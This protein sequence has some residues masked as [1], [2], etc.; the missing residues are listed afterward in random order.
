MPYCSGGMF[1]NKFSKLHMHRSETQS[2]PPNTKNA[3]HSTFFGLWC[4]HLSAF[5]YP[6]NCKGDNSAIKCAKC[7]QLASG[8][9]E[10]L[11]NMSH[12]LS[13]R[14]P[15]FTT[16][17]SGQLLGRFE[18]AISLESHSPWVLLITIMTRDIMRTSY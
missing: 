17:Y 5:P 1:R 12:R 11:L 18:H 13:S 10:S 14:T 7:K 16:T 15:L 3:A 9:A 4:R 6:K 8:W 2:L